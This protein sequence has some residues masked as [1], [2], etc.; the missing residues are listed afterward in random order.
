[1]G[2]T[3]FAPGKVIISGEHSVVHGRLALVTTLAKGVSVTVTDALTPTKTEDQD[4]GQVREFLRL[5]AKFWAELHHQPTEDLNFEYQLQIPIK[6]GLG[7]STALVTA[8]FR[9]LAEWFELPSDQ[10]QLLAD[11]IA[12]ESQQYP[13]SGVDQT[14]I[15]QEG[16]FVFQKLA[17]GNKI[18][19]LPVVPDDLSNFELIYS[20]QATETTAE[21]VALFRQ[22]VIDAGRHQL[23]AEMG[24]IT[25]QII[26]NA[27]N[28]LFDPE[29]ISANHRL[30]VEAGMVGAKAQAMIDQIEDQGGVAKISGAGGAR[31]GSGMIIAWNLKEEERDRHDQ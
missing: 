13:V 10:P 7:A 24:Q 14:A 25:Q 28:G 18:E 1:M 11:V 26:E 6:S 15:V 21:M 3:A 4:D 29:L 12:A 9:A 16:T 8:L 2:K 17:Q 27:Q 23:V 31:T 20:G 5:Q 22:N 30:L 19:P